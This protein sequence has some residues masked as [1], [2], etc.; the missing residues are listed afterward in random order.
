YS[1]RTAERI[2]VLDRFAKERI[3]AKGSPDDK[4]VVIPPWSFDDSIKFDQAGRRTFREAHGISKKFVV[5][6][7]GNHSPCHPL[8]SLLAAAD[9]LQ[10]SSSVVF[11][12]VGGGTEKLKVERF[13]ASRGLKNILS[14][15]YQP[16]AAISASL[17]AA[18]LQVV[19]MGDPFVGIVHPCKLY[20][21][22]RLCLTRGVGEGA[23]NQRPGTKDQR[24][25][26][27]DQ[28]LGTKDQRPQVLY[29]GPKTSHV[30]E[31]LDET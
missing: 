15:P 10:T 9:Q 26:S 20:N 4:L 14:L 12:F 13:A 29:I 31:V 23:M 6:Y 8:D 11:C 7:S 24:P 25:G 21:I 5:M 22:L 2:F 19:V 17:S 18:D 1:L 27:E 28:R 16:L 30:S 3:A